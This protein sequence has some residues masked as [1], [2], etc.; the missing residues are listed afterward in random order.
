MLLEHLSCFSLSKLNSNLPTISGEEATAVGHAYENSAG[1]PGIIG[2]MDSCHMA[3][4]KAPVGK[5]SSFYSNP[6]QFHSIHLLA[7]SDHRS[8][9][10]YVNVGRPG[11]F[12]E[13]KVFKRSS[14]CHIIDID[15][16]SIFPPNTHIIA[17]SSFPLSDH[18]LTPY[19]HTSYTALQQQQ[20]RH[21]RVYNDKLA[22]TKLPIEGAFKLLRTR[23]QRLKCLEMQHVSNMNIAIKTCC[24][25]HNICMANPDYQILSDFSLEDNID[26]TIAT[27]YSGTP[28]FKALRKRDMIALYLDGQTSYCR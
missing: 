7:V 8:K 27:E 26:K 5:S 6:M 10:T 1:I 17:N 18:V 9:F 19:N 15:P 2:S 11:S 16:S 20:T 3:I 4:N 28:P 12:H 23:W 14:L 25:L 13:S 22:A 21:Q 24:I